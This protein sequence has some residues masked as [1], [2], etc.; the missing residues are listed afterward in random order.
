MLRVMYLNR[1]LGLWAAVL[2]VLG[3]SLPA[4][5]DEPA[6]ARLSFWMPPERMAGFEAMY[7]EQVVPLLKQHGLAASPQRGRATVDSVFSRLFE[8]AMPFASKDI[9]AVL[10]DSAFGAMMQE[11]GT[12]NPPT[13]IRHELVLYS[14]PSGAGHSTVVGPGHAVL[15]GQGKRHW[16][17]YDETDGL[18][19]G[20][21]QAITQ[22]REGNMWFGTFQGGVC[23][24]DG[25][26][27]EIF[28]TKN[29]LPDDIVD[30]VF[31][32]RDGDIWIGTYNGLA[33]YNGVSF[34]TYTQQDNLPNNAIKAISQDLQGN[35]WIGTDG[36]LSR[37]DGQHFKSFTTQDGLPGNRVSSILQD[38]QGN[39][40]I[41]TDGGL[42]RYDGQQFIRFTVKEGLL[43]NR[44]FS[45]LQD[46]QGSLW[47]GTD[48]GLSRYDGRAFTN[49]TTGIARTIAQDS[50]GTLW[51]TTSKGLG[52]FAFVG[53]HFDS[54]S[55]VDGLS[56]GWIIRLFVDREGNL[57]VGT[58]GNVNCLPYEAGLTF[59][60]E[61]GLPENTVWSLAQ[62]RDGDMWFGTYSGVCRYD[63]RQLTI[64]TQDDGLPGNSIFRQLKD[65]KGDLWFGVLGSGI[66][67]YD[68][69]SFTSFTPEDGLPS[70]DVWSLGEDRDGSIWIGTNR[71][72]S[73]W[74]GKRF[75][76][77]TA[78]D[79]LANG[80]VIAIL[81]DRRGDL[82][83]GTSYGLSRWDGE[84]FTNFAAVDGLPG[85]NVTALFED[86]RG[87]LW[88]GTAG[89]FVARWDGE[90]FTAFTSADGV[91]GNYG[92]AIVQDRKGVLWI[93]SW[94]GGI[95]LWDGCLFQSLTQKD[96]L[97]NNQVRSL[98]EDRAGNMWVG[99]AGGIS[100]V[101]R[102]A[103]SP[104]LVSIDAV[105]AD[106][107]YVHEREVSV[108]SNVGRITFEF[109]GTS[110]KTRQ[111]GLVYRY[112][113]RDYDRD[114]QTTR[115][116]RV[117]YENLTRGTYTFEVQAVDRDLNYSAP[118]QVQVSVHLPYES[119]AWIS[120]A[121][122]GVL[123]FLW[124]TGRVVRRGRRLRE[125]NTTLSVTNKDLEEA[126][127]TAE[128]A[129]QAKSLFLA[130]MSHE[131]RTP[132]NAILG[133]AQILRRA[134]DLPPPHRQAVETIERSGDQL[135]RLI[136]DVLDISKIEVG[137]MDLNPTDFDL[138]ELLEG[139]GVMFQMRCREQ[140]LQWRLEGI[141]SFSRPVHGDE[142]KLSQVL[143]NLLSNAVKFT[144]QGEV[145]LNVT[146]QAEDRYCFEVMDT[147][148]G[149][150]PAEIQTLF[151]P[152]QQGQAGVQRG[153]TGLGLAIARRQVEL[154]GGQLAVQSKL[155]E[156]SRFF[157]TVPLPSAQVILRD[158]ATESFDRVQRLAAGFQVRALVAD[159][160]AENRDILSRM[161]E[162]IGVQ[163]EVAEDGRQALER[164]AV[165]LPAIAFLDIRMPGMD[166]VEVMRR[167]WEE[168]GREEMKVVAVSASALDHER[169]HYLE[170]GF[171][172]FLDKPVR[173]EQ[174][175]A[176]LARLLKVEYEYAEP[177]REGTAPLELQGVSLPPELFQHLKNAAELSS[178]TELEK[179][180]D[181]VERL[182][183]GA[184]RLATHLRA[185]SQDFRMEEVLAIL[186]R[187]GEQG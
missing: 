154:L 67:R 109:H 186:D 42:C 95:S 3:L 8:V 94:S 107:R 114:W 84:H 150:A 82:W 147:G 135:L 129:N 70:P 132:M 87:H 30:A 73:R 110:F 139:L 181:E 66:C 102:A 127:E 53:D 88:V 160:V 29:G 144:L 21:V 164:L 158:E 163:V 69:H 106:R 45:I 31:Q 112:R 34:V 180:L 77:F 11:L 72:V 103:L 20:V 68:G 48:K 137:R 14:V 43:S 33:R 168:W 54:L 76:T 65:R 17:S 165:H 9:N 182:G 1:C 89:D 149:I 138:H 119:M 170:A 185:L 61:N 32:D 38:H 179:Y 86:D 146:A 79:G 117:E 26:H 6:L 99:T 111:N 59:T 166:G 100:R 175:Y 62:D 130:N 177:A 83:F 113:L 71:G 35:L 125:A 162:D 93:G 12:P 5:A 178:V 155:G 169:Q 58:Y 13:P 19:G 128:S 37:Y 57:W 116:M 25:V 15:I 101:R 75:T 161:L 40:W 156:G 90:R 10:E 39:L 23:R 49:Y 187:L 171:D 74:D 184:S 55:V 153:G 44:I 124:Q 22:D 118:A 159:D 140:G 96:G 27:F 157:F 4:V 16:I 122:A 108:S 60:S 56:D 46:H 78:A 141:D 121:L 91:T 36:G 123:L 134:R 104:P 167:I 105:V 143:M 7:R 115:T 50:T 131:I 63:G 51:F 80:R 136:N 41:G 126:R 92:W 145:V 81:Q 183:G 64:Y 2:L 151:Q 52:Y 133:Y 85:E 142:A 152:F 98:Y 120:V 24:F 47:V 173:L 148:M 174:L 28:N 97:A 172:D 176:C 18:A